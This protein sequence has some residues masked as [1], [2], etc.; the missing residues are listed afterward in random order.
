MNVFS[1]LKSI[2]HHL[3]ARDVRQQTQLKLRII[4]R[5]EFVAGL[6]DEGAPDAPAHFCA[7]RNILQVGI[8]GRKPARRRDGLI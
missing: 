7:N 2:E 6:G 8:A 4:G 1:V 3:V 5:D